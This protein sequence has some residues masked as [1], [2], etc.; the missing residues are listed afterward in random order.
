METEGNRFLLYFTI[1]MATEHDLGGRDIKHVWNIFIL[2]NKTW[3][4][5]NSKKKS[6]S[7]FFMLTFC[8]VGFKGHKLKPNTAHVT[9]LPPGVWWDSEIAN[10]QRVPDP[11]RWHSHLG[12]K[13]SHNGIPNQ[14]LNHT[15][16]VCNVSTW[17][18]HE[19][20]CGKRGEKLPNSI[21]TYFTRKV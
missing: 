4:Q 6:L 2:V 13:G 1:Q 7:W 10:K 9:H 5:K 17:P 14:P 15:P 16:H 18:S 21:W 20:H 3:S 8:S 12:H 19:L 11:R